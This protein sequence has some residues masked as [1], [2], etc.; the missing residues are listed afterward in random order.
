MGGSFLPLGFKAISGKECPLMNYSSLYIYF[1]RPGFR[2][3][4]SAAAIPRQ[5]IES[6]IFQNVAS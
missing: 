2:F 6:L 4:Q 5:K 3:L 1:K